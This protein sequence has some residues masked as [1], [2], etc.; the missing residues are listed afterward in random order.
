MRLKYSIIICFICTII[1]SQNKNFEP[2][3]QWKDT[4]GVHINAHGGGILFVDG[5][6]YWYGEHKTEGKSGNT[7]LV[8][9]S[10]YSSK[11]LYNWKNEGIVLKAEENPNSEITKGCIME[12][13]KVIFNKKMSKYILWFHLELKDQGY[14]AAKAAVAIS[15]S[16]KGPFKFYKSYRPNKGVWPIGFKNE[17]KIASAD[18]S[19]LKSWTPEWLTAVDNG[20]LVRRDFEKGQMS[21]DMTVYV[22]DNN[23]AYLIHSSED[24][25]TLHISELTDDYLDFTEKW[26]R[27]APAGH[28]EAP[29]VFKKNGIY[30]MITSGCTGWDPN[31]A[32]SFS[33]NSVLGPW[34]SLGNPCVGED[35]ALTFHS[36]STYIFP[37]QGK[38]EQFI[39]MA[40]RWKPEN[41]IDGSY[42]WLPIK[43][44]NE[45]PILK[46]AEKW[47]LNAFAE[48]L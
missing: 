5:V 14:N 18:E 34:K 21:R 35:A 36:Q 29:A 48:K 10:C 4:D 37:I 42:I 6:Y 9:F 40:D 15:D 39:F 26:T 24:N 17:N 31:E 16:P 3:K 20:M 19:K 8:G 1:Y 32:R 45:K 28:N 13:P 27:M 41:P 44:A 47:N 43:F 11:D 12:R 46:W 2:G 23:K 33:A 38:K 7:S 22:D 25:L 30:Y